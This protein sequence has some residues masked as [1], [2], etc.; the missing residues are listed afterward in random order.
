MGQ[1]FLYPPR[2]P[3]VHLVGEEN[4]ARGAVAP[5]VAKDTLTRDSRRRWQ[6]ARQARIREAEKHSLPRTYLLALA[7]A[8]R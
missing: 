4:A 2:C 6:L 1:K 5:S 3:L 7:I 8:G